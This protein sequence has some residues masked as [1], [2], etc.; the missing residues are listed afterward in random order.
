MISDK[1]AGEEGGKG[2]LLIG[3][4]ELGR[5]TLSLNQA[6]SNLIQLLAAKLSELKGLQ[7]AM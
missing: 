4:K 2:S 6:E 7:I 5:G 3:F 1:S